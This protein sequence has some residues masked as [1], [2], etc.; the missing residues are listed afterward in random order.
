[1]SYVPRQWICMISSTML[2]IMLWMDMLRPVLA[3]LK[4]RRSTTKGP[5]LPRN[6]VINARHVGVGLNLKTTLRV[7]WRLCKK[8]KAYFSSSILQTAT[9]RAPTLGDSLFSKQELPKKPC[10]PVFLWLFLWLVSERH[11]APQLE[12]QGCSLLSFK[13]NFQTLWPVQR[14]R[15][16]QLRRQMLATRVPLRRPHS[17]GTQVAWELCMTGRRTLELQTAGSRRAPF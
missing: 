5:K 6:S 3:R 11:P 7:L 12:R 16:F 10:D 8:G 14:E 17:V 1:M 13:N 2:I 4:R 15:R 9:Q